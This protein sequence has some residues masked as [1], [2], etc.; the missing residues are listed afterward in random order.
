MPMI[1]HLLFLCF[2]VSLLVYCYIHK[3]F[4]YSGTQSPDGAGRGGPVLSCNYS[5]WTTN[6]A[7][8]WST[9]QSKLTNGIW[10]AN[11]AL[12][13]FQILIII[14]YFLII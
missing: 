13:T 8:V 9:S 1:T 12:Y 11:I 6:T 5:R 3:F 7:K 14:W 4:F 10:A 2:F